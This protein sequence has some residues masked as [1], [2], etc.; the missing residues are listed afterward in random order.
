MASDVGIKHELLITDVTHM[1]GEKVCIVG[2]DHHGTPIRPILPPP[3]IFQSRLLL[4][5]GVIRPRAV[6][7]APWKRRRARRLTNGSGINWP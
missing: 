4:P 6:I 1:Q 5:T 2:I 7:E 3:G